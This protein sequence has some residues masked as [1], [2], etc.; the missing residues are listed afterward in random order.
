MTPRR[1]LR[2]ACVYSLRGIIR[3]TPGVRLPR[4]LLRPAAEIV[5][6]AALAQRLARDAGVAAMQDQ[7]MM[8]ME[9]VCVRHNLFEVQLALER[10]QS[11]RHGGAVADAKDVRVDRDGL[12]AERDVEH[13]VRGL[14]PDAGQRLERLAA[15]RNLSAMLRHESA[16]E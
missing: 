15:A 5:D 2:S 16:R 3:R 6:D 10:R 4:R 7:P 13:D 12:L 11:R 8:R 14:A 1:R 9:L